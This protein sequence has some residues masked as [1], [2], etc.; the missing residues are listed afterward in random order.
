MS[1]YNAEKYLCE[2]IDS[3]LNQ[4]FKEFEFVIINDGSTDR[5]LEIIQSYDDDRVVLI[6]QKNT[7]LAKTLNNGIAIAKADYIARM[8]AD[9]IALLTRFKMQY[10]FLKG[11]PAYV[12]VG[13]N[14]DRI[15]MAGNY[16][17]TS[18]VRLS[19]KKIKE[20]LPKNP[21]VHPSVMFHKKSAINCGGYPE[22]M[23]KAQD[24]VFFNRL[25]KYG[26][27]ANLPNVLLKYRILPTANSVQ[28]IKYLAEYQKVI[29]KAINGKTISDGDLI[30]TKVLF[31]NR[32]TNDRKFFYY[33]YLSKKY[34]WNNYQPYL[35]RINLKKALRLYPLKFIPYGLLILSFIP[36]RIIKHFYKKKKKSRG[37]FY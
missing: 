11:N 34:L 1:V 33:I 21:F 31:S 10:D 2:A 13:S 17:Y 5:S 4:T 3:I 6:D 27:F 28:N 30:K 32:H 15:D 14:V 19:N 7:G 26:K 37:F 24:V 12:I 25:S 36:N 8:D 22:F 23:L 18:N 35:A 20:Y 9:D 29:N 16:V